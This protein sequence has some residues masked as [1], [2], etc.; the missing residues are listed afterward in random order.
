MLGRTKSIQ[1]FA[2]SVNGA[3]PA[4][5]LRWLPEYRLRNVFVAPIVKD[6]QIAIY[7]SLQVR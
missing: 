3:M 4:G 2:G 6:C 7:D 1:V 5:V